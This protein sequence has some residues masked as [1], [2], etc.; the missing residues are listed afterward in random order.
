[1][2]TPEQTIDHFRR[3]LTAVLAVKHA[4]ASLAG[5]AFAWGTAV[6]VLRASAGAS[7][8][9]LD[10]RREVARL[11]GQIEVLKEEKVLDAARAG[12]LQKKLE[13]V[14]DEASGREP[15]RTL[16]ALDRVADATGRKAK[17]AAEAAV[18]K[19]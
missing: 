9:P 3:R 1:M 5:W 12:D 16:E 8:P 10:V 19:T 13:Q 18:R 2:S 7:A 4:A 11:S 6:P 17:E 14:R 15:A